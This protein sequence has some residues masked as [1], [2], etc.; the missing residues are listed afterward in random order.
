MQMLRK[1]IP[2]SLKAQ[3]FLLKKKKKPH[4]QIK[5]QVTRAEENKKDVTHITEGQF[6][7]HLKSSF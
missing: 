2:L 1:K 4:R 3:K 5:G 7:S 6:A